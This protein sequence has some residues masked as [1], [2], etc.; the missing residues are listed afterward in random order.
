VNIYAFAIIAS[1]NEIAWD[2]T[3]VMSIV[4][5]ADSPEVATTKAEEQAR[6][7]YPKSHGWQIKTSMVQVDQQELL[8][9][10]DG[11]DSNTET[12]VVSGAVQDS[13]EPQN[14]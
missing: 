11:S 7:K 12:R 6:R 14:R 2:R 3:E 8:R 4:I 5:A 1:R 9:T 13:E 10:I